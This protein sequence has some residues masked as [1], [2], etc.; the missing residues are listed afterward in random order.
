MFTKDELDLDTVT[1]SIV[2]ALPKL[3]LFEQR[4][5]IEL[6]RL[7]DSVVSSAEICRRK[8]TCTTQ[9]LPALQ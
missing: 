3:D 4:L 1:A 7:L 5:S 8:L 6:Y 2:N 9:L